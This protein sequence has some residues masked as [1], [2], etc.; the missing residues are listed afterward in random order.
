MTPSAGPPAPGT[1]AVSPVI[2]ISQVDEF[3]VLRKS[4]ELQP[5]GPM[6]VLRENK[7]DAIEGRTQEVSSSNQSLGA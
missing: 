1:E 2:E 5:E 6:E 4:A 3:P 7:S